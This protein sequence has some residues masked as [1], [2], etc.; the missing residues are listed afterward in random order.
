MFSAVVESLR[1]YLS[2]HRDEVDLAMHG[3]NN[4]LRND[5]TETSAAVLAREIGIDL[6]DHTAK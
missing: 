4:L 6:Q 5:E 1:S 2:L 3:M